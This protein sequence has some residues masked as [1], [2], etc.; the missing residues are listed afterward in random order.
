[1]NENQEDKGLAYLTK[2]NKSPDSPLCLA[3]EAVGMV[4]RILE[5][6]E[7]RFHS[8]IF[9]AVEVLR[10]AESGE[11]DEVRQAGE[12]LNDLDKERAHK[13]SPFKKKGWFSK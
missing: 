12:R 9:A 5:Q 4:I 11:M 7:P 10:R 3:G 13:E 6:T 8:A 1:M 2:D